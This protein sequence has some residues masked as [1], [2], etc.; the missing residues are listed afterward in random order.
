M[1]NSYKLD[2]IVPDLQLQRV[3]HI[4]V[5]LFIQGQTISKRR[6]QVLLCA[7]AP[8]PCNLSTYPP[9]PTI[10]STLHHRDAFPRR[11][12]VPLLVR[13]DCN[14]FTCNSLKLLLWVVLLMVFLDNPKASASMNKL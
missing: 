8:P 7:T 2:I 4:K 13:L 1:W 12:D 5:I 14:W 10:G 9:N 11:G 6:T 3:S